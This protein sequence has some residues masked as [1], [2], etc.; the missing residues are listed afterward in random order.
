MEEKKR[1]RYDVDVDDCRVFLCDL[2]KK[3]QQQKKS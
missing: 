2:K 3:E 1:F